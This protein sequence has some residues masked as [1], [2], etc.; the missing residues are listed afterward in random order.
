[1]T[2]LDYV[3]VI[4]LMVLGFYGILKLIG[5]QEK[6]QAAAFKSINAY[7]FPEK[8]SASIKNKYPHLSD[9]EVDSILTGLKQFFYA[10]CICKGKSVGM[11]SRSVDYAWHKFILHTK[12]YQQF[13]KKNIGWF[14]HHTPAGKSKNEMA[15]FESTKRI[16]ITCCLT[17]NIDARKPKSLPLLFSLD[18]ELKIP[19]GLF[20]NLNNH[21]GKGIGLGIDC[22]SELSEFTTNNGSYSSCSA[23]SCSSCGGGGD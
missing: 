20:F 7:V 23:S 1:M 13:C 11:P 18:S 21:P 22:V 6:R 10:N 4:V 9:K 14:V 2:S 19:D 12:A 8:V 15:E 17:E 5:R 3:I 16:W